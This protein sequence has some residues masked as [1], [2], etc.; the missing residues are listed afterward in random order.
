MLSRHVLTHSRKAQLS[1]GVQWGWSE[2]DVQSQ[3]E[4]QKATP[5]T[6]PLGR[7]GTFSPSS[8]VAPTTG[9]PTTSSGPR[10]PQPSA[11]ITLPG[12]VHAGVKRPGSPSGQYD[13]D[14]KQDPPI[15]DLKR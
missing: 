8:F 12:H 6:R 10:P 13:P 9:G 14:S 15:P 11:A 2:I 4:T 3:P 7:P 5:P 1:R